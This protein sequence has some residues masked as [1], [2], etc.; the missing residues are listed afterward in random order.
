MLIAVASAEGRRPRQNQYRQQGRQQ[1]SELPH[2]EVFPL[3]NLIDSGQT[4]HQRNL[5]SAPNVSQTRVGSSIAGAKNSVRFVAARFRHSGERRNPGISIP[6]DAGFAGVT[7]REAG[8]FQTKT[9]GNCYNASGTSRFLIFYSIFGSLVKNFLAVSIQRTPNSALCLALAER[10]ASL[11]ATKGQERRAPVMVSC[12][13][14]IGRLRKRQGSG[15]QC[16]NKQCH[17]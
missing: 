8:A 2:G 16:N 5:G 17:R 12:G 9:W 3:K 11:G 4:A 13:K 7:A 10:P 6:W 15:N 14:G 1:D